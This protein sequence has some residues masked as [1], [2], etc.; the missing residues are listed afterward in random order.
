MR[1]HTNSSASIH[2]LRRG[3]RPVPV[4][5]I[6]RI[7]SYRVNGR[8]FLSL[9]PRT[10]GSGG[11]AL[12]SVINDDDKDL[13]VVAEAATHAANRR[14]KA[15]FGNW[16]VGARLR[17]LVAANLSD[18]TLFCRFEEVRAKNF[19]SGIFQRPDVRP[20]KFLERRGSGNDLAIGGLE[21]KRLDIAL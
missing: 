8:L 18:F 17:K 1:W 12:D 10:N 14:N 19:A 2:A 13:L 11:L 4:P 9:G 16:R 6:G 20:K 15:H 21:T 3:W 5:A 7:T